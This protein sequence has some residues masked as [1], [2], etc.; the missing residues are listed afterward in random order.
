MDFLKEEQE[1]MYRALPSTNKGTGRQRNCYCKEQDSK[2]SYCGV[3]DKCG[4]RGH[5]RHAPPPI[6]ATGS[7]CDE[8]YSLEAAALADRIK[9]NF[10]RNSQK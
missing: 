9:K 1:K 7:W 2:E 3:C 5:L 8:C 4:K 6:P 10:K